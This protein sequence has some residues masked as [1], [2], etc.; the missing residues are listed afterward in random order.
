MVELG[1][2]IKFDPFTK[3]IM[4]PTLILE[5]RSGKALGL[6]N[7]TDLNMSFTAKGLQEISFTTHKAVNGVECEFWDK[8]RGLAVIRYMIE[9][10][11]YIRFEA[12]FS[13]IDGDETVKSCNAVSLETELGQRT[14]REFYVNDPNN[15]QDW[16][17]YDEETGMATP[18]VLWNENDTAHSLLTRALERV[19]HWSVGEVSE[20]FN[21]GNTVSRADTMQRTFSINGSTVYDFLEGDVCREF[22][23]VFMYDTV[24]RTINCYNL[25]DCVWMYSSSP[26]LNG[27]VA[28]DITYRNHQFYDKD[29]N[30]IDNDNVYIEDSEGTLRKVVYRYCDGIGKDTGILMSKSRLANSFQISENKDSVKNL[31][32]ITAGD[33]IMTNLG[34][35]A[36][37]AT[38][39]TDI[40]LFDNFVYEDMSDE[41]RNKLLGDGVSEMGYTNYLKEEQKKFYGE[42]EIVDLITSRSYETNPTDLE[43]ANSF[44][45][46]Y[47]SGQLQSGLYLGY[48]N[49]LTKQS[50]YEHSMSPSTSLSVTTA[51]EQLN[52]LTTKL[53]TDT[54]LVTVKPTATAYT[55]VTSTLSKYFKTYI[56]TRYDID[57]DK[58]STSY[59]VN[60]ATEGV[61]HGKV[62]IT[63]AIDSTDTVTSGTLNVAVRYVN[64]SDTTSA[65]QTAYIE[66]NK[67]KILMQ[68]ANGDLA[69]LNM[70]VNGQFISNTELRNLLKQYSLSMLE[71]FYKGMQECIATLIE[72]KNK[73]DTI[74][75]A[76][77][78]LLYAEWQAR[79]A[80]CEEIYNFRQKQVVGW[81]DIVQKL[82]TEIGMFQS[83]LDIQRYLAD[84]RQNGNPITIDQMCS[85]VGVDREKGNQILDKSFAGIDKAVIYDENTGTSIVISLSDYNITVNNN[86]YKEYCSYLRENEYQNSNYISDGLSDAEI[87]KKGKELIETATKELCK[88]TVLQRSISGDFNNIFAVEELEQ[89]YSSFDLYNYVRCSV[90]GHIYKLRLMQVSFN[91][92]NPES[93]PVTFA[94]YIESIDGKMNDVQNILNSAQSISSSYS[95]TYQQAR[96][97]GE[98]GTIINKI[99]NEGLNSAEVLIKNSDAEEV[100]IDNTGI[101]A[102]SMNDVGAYGNHQ[103]KIIGN[104][105]YL[106]EDNWETVSMAVGLG[107]YEGEWKYGVWA[108]LLYGKIILGEQLII[109]GDDDN[110][111]IQGDEIIIT[112]ISDNYD[113]TY[114]R[115]TIT[116]SGNNIFKIENRWLG[117]SYDIFSIDTEGVLNISNTTNILV[118][119][120]NDDCR[121]GRIVLP[122]YNRYNNHYYFDPLFGDTMMLKTPREDSVHGIIL[123]DLDGL[124][125]YG[126]N[127]G[128]VD[129]HNYL[130]YDQNGIYG[131]WQADDYA[132]TGNY[133]YLEFSR[134]RIETDHFGI[135]WG[136]YTLMG[137]DNLEIETTNWHID[138]NGLAEFNSLELETFKI[139]DVK[140]E[141]GSFLTDLNSYNIPAIKNVVDNLGAFNN[142][143]VYLSKT[144]GGSAELTLNAKYIDI[145]KLRIVT[146]LDGGSFNMPTGGNDIYVTL[147]SFPN[148]S[149]IRG[150]LANVFTEWMAGGFLD[151]SRAYGNGEV[152]LSYNNNNTG[153]QS[154]TYIYC[155][156]LYII[157]LP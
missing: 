133:R 54:L 100:I 127:D 38:G 151:G 2:L 35:A 110:V 99:Q 124:C 40:V 139:D 121:I 114:T 53:A 116:T 115:C 136:G 82:A 7:Y 147:S 22:G 84:I 83:Y 42:P 149:Y 1:K 25:D 150:V 141:V 128:I 18:T 104:G 155:R 69:N 137:A 46:Q 28:E 91:E 36:A 80:I 41:L 96:S 12:S 23:C 111:Q 94:Q 87:L 89:L 95:S 71:G 17:D 81:N 50:F 142:M 86:L 88:A 135:S 65:G 73:L 109:G 98:A 74:H 66:Y 126:N 72:L 21:D 157:Q 120:H 44:Y 31:F 9:G 78:D 48:A 39:N 90:D 5:T 13:V 134:D 117:V 76:S 145:G 63:R 97:G 140:Q 92:E 6:I 131:A 105:M 11:K 146:I 153:G 24:N 29:G 68:I 122:Q 57:I 85:I 102:R 138:Y 113:D 156:M 101:V 32:H 108:D 45:D 154:S 15:L 61:W 103:L 64:S 27:K 144:S 125:F 49:S 79:S 77:F 132:E 118:S 51:Q 59:T 4:R 26:E 43:T 129:T 119:T 107:L 152:Y 67:Q 93:L 123:L 3:Q 106:T 34:V 62:T 55:T 70:I 47:T 112:N 14:L 10:E 37:N 33:D 56:D 8:L 20:Y 143:S 130:R 58:E 60:T 30:L 19:P 148:G 52:I 16:L 75:S